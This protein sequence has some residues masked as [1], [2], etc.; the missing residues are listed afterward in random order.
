M[1]RASPVRQVGPDP[2]QGLSSPHPKG[3][4]EERPWF[5][6]V[7]CLTKKWQVTKIQREGDVTKSQFCLSLTHSGIGKFV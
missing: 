5:R 2:F 7:T 3:E 4:R 1:R 6:L